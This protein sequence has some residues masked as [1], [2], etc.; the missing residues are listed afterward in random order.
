MCVCVTA[1]PSICYSPRHEEEE[2]SETRCPC[3][4]YVA[5]VT[6]ITLWGKDNYFGGWEGKEVG[7]E[8]GGSD[9]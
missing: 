4:F 3:E 5:M 2:F 7:G 1:G 9:P 6:I 8:G